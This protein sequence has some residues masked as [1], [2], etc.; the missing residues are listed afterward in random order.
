LTARRASKVAAMNNMN[1]LSLA[2]LLLIAASAAIAG[3]HKSTGALADQG[4]DYANAKVDSAGVVTATGRP[5]DLMKSLRTKP[6]D[7]EQILFGDLHVHSTVS[8]DAFRFLAACIWWDR[9]ASAG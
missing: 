6:G 7:N 2:L 4:E 1:R 9:C 8:W 5:A 3:P